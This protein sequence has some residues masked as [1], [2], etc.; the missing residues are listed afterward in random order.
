M[1]IGRSS[2]PHRFS[3]RQ[4]NSHDNDDDDETR[5]VAKDSH[6]RWGPSSRTSHDPQRQ[7]SAVTVVLSRCLQTLVSS[8]TWNVTVRVI[9]VERNVTRQFARWQRCSDILP[10]SPPCVVIW[11]GGGGYDCFL[12]DVCI[13]YNISSE[14]EYL[15]YTT[16]NRQQLTPTS[17]PQRRYD[18]NSL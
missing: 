14:I 11:N 13:K 3:R 17:N 5:R 6:Q 16:T 1:S 7:I 8:C 2:T 15:Y 18:S 10:Y 12:G 4:S 9:V